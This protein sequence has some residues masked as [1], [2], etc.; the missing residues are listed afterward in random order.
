M[1]AGDGLFKNSLKVGKGKE[2]TAQL[3]HGV[4]DDSL[5][6]ALRSTHHKFCRKKSSLNIRLLF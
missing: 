2:P 4:V 5:A 1:M 6:R 3:N